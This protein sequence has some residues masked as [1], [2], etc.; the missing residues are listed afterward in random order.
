MEARK[1]IAY[2]GLTLFGISQ[3]D[4]AHASDV[5]YTGPL[6]RPNAGILPRGMVNIEP[7]LVHSSSRYYYVNEGNK[8]RQS[9]TAQ[10]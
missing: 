2:V 7:Y 3:M 6:L 9:R 10:W 8:H 4:I 1:S 5:N